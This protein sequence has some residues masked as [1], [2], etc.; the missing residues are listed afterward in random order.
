[1]AVTSTVSARSKE[2]TCG[3]CHIRHLDH[4]DQLALKTKLV[5]AALKV[6][7]IEVPDV[8]DILPSVN[9]LTYRNK[10]QFAIQRDSE[11]KKVVGLYELNTNIVAGK[12]VCEI[13]HQLVNKVLQQFRTFLRHHDV[14]IY[15]E[16]TRSGSLRHLVVIQDTTHV[17]TT[18][19]Q[20]VSNSTEY[21]GLLT[22]KAQKTKLRSKLPK[23]VPLGGRNYILETIAGVKVKVSLN[24]FLQSNPLQ[25]ACLYEEVLKC[26]QDSHGGRITSTS[27]AP[28]EEPASPPLDA[29][30]PSATTLQSTTFTA[31]VPVTNE[32]VIPRVLWDLYCGV[33]TIGLYLA[34]TPLISQVI[35]VESVQEAVLDARENAQLNNITNIHFVQGLAEGIILSNGFTP[36]A[37][38]KATIDADN[39]SSQPHITLPALQRNDIVILN[40]PRKGCHVSLLS[41]LLQSQ[42][43]TIVYISCNPKTMARDIKIL[44]SLD[45]TKVGNA[46]KK[47]C[48]AA[49]GERETVYE[50]KRIQ[51]VDM[52]PQTTH[53][54]TVVWLERETSHQ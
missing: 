49:K 43:R 19:E 29:T 20:L 5:T 41:A 30:K 8:A 28:P 31:T 47:K 40:P 27:P 33:G 10:A 11:G 9:Q 46:L 54:E 32:A 39:P 2:S 17:S 7:N 26:I 48:N 15:N 14:S 34:N 42:A 21:D 3:G 45:S 37:T 1:M 51:P 44:T 36:G 23:T 16:T 22:A 24:S 4:K 6:F 12:H 13:Q 35:G 50:I 53:V 52:F 38:T 18:T 25:T